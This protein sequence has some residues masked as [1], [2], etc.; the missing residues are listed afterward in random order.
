MATQAKITSLEA[1]DAFRSSLIVFQS[2]AR[3]SMDDVG[4]EV[5]QT[6]QWLQHEKR[7]HWET[8][9]RQRTKKL[10]QAE[11]ELLSAKLAGHRDALIVRQAV[12]QRA[13]QALAEAEGKLHAVKKWMM[14]YDSISDPIHK[15]LD[16]LR[17]Y[18]E[19]DLPKA[20]AYL[21]NTQKTLE[22]Y[23]DAPTSMHSAAP[24]AAPETPDTAQP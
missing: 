15:R 16:E 1:L 11:Q 20:V 12:V 24:A 5:R 9:I 14:Q 2:K 6:R 7:L 23:T 22:S 3:R 17:Q 8:E 18:L 19:F 10:A 4:D 13:K 21:V